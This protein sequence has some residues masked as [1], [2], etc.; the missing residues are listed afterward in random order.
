MSNVVE[1][2]TPPPKSPEYYLEILT[3]F[4]EAARSGQMTFL[5]IDALIDGEIRSVCVGT[6]IK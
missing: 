2:K 3:G 5:Q 1:L 6:R 4:L